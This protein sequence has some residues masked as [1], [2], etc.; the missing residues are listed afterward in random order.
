[1]KQ[2]VVGSAEPECTV[3]VMHTVCAVTLMMRPRQDTAAVSLTLNI[4]Q[5]SASKSW[6]GLMQGLIKLDWLYDIA[7]ISCVTSQHDVAI[8]HAKQLQKATY[9]ASALRTPLAPV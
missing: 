9:Q 6:W 2:E 5:Q 3:C 8:F 1:M 7:A 4:A